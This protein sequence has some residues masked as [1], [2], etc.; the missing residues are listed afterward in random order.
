[1]K[2]FPKLFRFQVHFRIVLDVVILRGR[3][4]GGEASRAEREAGEEA[5]VAVGGVEAVGG[6]EGGEDG[7]GGAAA[8]GLEQSAQSELRPRQ[9]GRGEGHVGLARRAG[10]HHLF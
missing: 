9:E 8:P 7:S 3:R 6:A 5:G 1:M 10:G 2:L 4:P